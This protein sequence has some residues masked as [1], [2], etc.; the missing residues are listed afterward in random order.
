MKT[1]IFV[2]ISLLLIAIIGVIVYFDQSYSPTFTSAAVTT[3]T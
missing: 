3:A 1:K 2:I